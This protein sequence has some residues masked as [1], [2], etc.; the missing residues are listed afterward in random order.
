MRKHMTLAAS[1]VQA[2]LITSSPSYRS[3]SR[4]SP[5]SQVI[6]RSTTQRTFPRPLPCGVRRLPMCGSIPIQRSSAL[7]AS[8]S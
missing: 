1:V 2:S 7:G 6:V 5:F 4:R 3:R 8:L